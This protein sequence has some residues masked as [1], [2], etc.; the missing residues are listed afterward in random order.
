M[1]SRVE[2]ICVISVFSDTALLPREG[3]YVWM[4]RTTS[5]SE[6]TI[7]LDEVE[8]ESG[9]DFAVGELSFGLRPC[10]RLTVC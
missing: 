7:R 2:V 3:R 6:S 1:G 4:Y 10:K 5:R 9:R 8:V